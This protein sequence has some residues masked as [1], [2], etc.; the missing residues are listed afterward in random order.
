MASVDAAGGSGTVVGGKSV[1]AQLLG[2]STLLKAVMA[3]TG[4]VWVGFLVGHLGTNARVFGGAQMLNE[5]YASL[6]SNLLLFWGVRVVL[7]T[8][9]VA[10]VVAAVTLQRRSFAARPVRYKKRRYKAASLASR[11]MPWSGVVIGLFILFHLLHL[12]TGQLMPAGAA[13]VD[14]DDYHNIVASFSVW[15]V[16]LAY[17]LCIALVGMHLWHGLS[18]ATLSIGL[19]HPRYARLLRWGPASLVVGLVLGMLAI[20]LSVLFGCVR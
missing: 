4:F 17:V 11:T 19:R 6:K 15:Y 13:F 10:H 2:S 1:D 8:S 12:T 18:S 16:A 7:A 20:P 5:Y 3:V 14:G 9:V